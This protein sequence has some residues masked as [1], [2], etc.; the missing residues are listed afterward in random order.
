M[1]SI[2]HVCKLSWQLWLL[3]IINSWARGLERGLQGAHMRPEQVRE[4][5]DIVSIAIDCLPHIA[6]AYYRSVI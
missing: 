5:Y 1:L 4:A 3:K 6:M 2:L